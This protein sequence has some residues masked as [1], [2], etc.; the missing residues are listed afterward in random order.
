LAK[1]LLIPEQVA[2]QYFNCDQYEIEDI[3]YEID[4]QPSFYK[5]LLK[6]KSFQIRLN[7][8]PNLKA[9]AAVR[10]LDLDFLI[11]CLEQEPDLKS[12]APEAAAFI[13]FADA[14]KLL[15]SDGVEPLP[16]ARSWAQIKGNWEIVDLIDSHNGFEP[17]LSDFTKLLIFIDHVQFCIQSTMYFE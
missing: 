5:L 16:G 3:I 13:G 11:K 4:L 12:R 8:S 15:L 10:T 6:N 7:V 2:V 14:F 1:A 9:F 17:N